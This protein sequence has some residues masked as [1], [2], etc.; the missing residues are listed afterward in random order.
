MD[1][2]IPIEPFTV[3]LDEGVLADLRDRIRRTRWPSHDPP[4]G[5]DYG[6]D[7][8][9][10]RSLLATWAEEFDWRNEEEKLNRL[11]HY[12]AGIGGARI[13][14]LHERGKGPAPMPIVLTPPMA[15]Q[16]LSSSTSGC[17][18]CSQTRPPTA[19]GLRTPSMW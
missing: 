18:R 16:A 3:A 12:R 17:C 2:P 1:D 11:A 19:V 13:H 5:W 10:L 14:F 7:P 8:A 6:T 9:Y 15:F 4:S